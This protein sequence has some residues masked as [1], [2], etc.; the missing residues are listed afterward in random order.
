MIPG[1]PVPS[2]NTRHL[3]FSVLTA[4]SISL[5]GFLVNHCVGSLQG[6]QQDDLWIPRASG[7]TLR[8]ADVH[9][10][11]LACYHLQLTLSLLFFSRRYYKATSGLMLDVGAYVKALEVLAL[12]SGLDNDDILDLSGKE[13]VSNVQG[14]LLASKQA[15]LF[16]LLALILF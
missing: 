6:W 3:S 12:L 5:Q 16:G 1:P 7:P 4:G 9:W 2:Q 11:L 15:S 14:S 8:L 10:S 13:S